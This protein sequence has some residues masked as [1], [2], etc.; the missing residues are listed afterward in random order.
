MSPSLLV[1]LVLT[2]NLNVGAI[3]VKLVPKTGTPPSP[4]ELPGFT[5][6]SSSRKLFIYGGRLGNMY[7]D[8]WEFDLDTQRWT[9]IHPGVVLTPGPRSD[10]FMRV[11]QNQREILLFGGDTSTGP[12]SDVWLYDIE[13][14]SVIY[15]QW[16]LVDDKGKSPPRAFYRSVCKYLH[17]GK[18]Y[19]AVYG[20]QG[21]TGLVHN[22]YMYYL[23]RLEIETFTWTEYQSSES[24]PETCG[25]KMGYY[26]GSLYLWEGSCIYKFDLQS[27]EW[28]KIVPSSKNLNA[29]TDNGM[30]IY[31]DSLYS[32]HGWDKVNSRAM[33]YIYK[34]NLIGE[35]YEV[36]QTVIEKEGV[37]DWLF[38]FEC[39]DNM[40]YIFSGGAESGNYNSLVM[41]DLDNL[42]TPL[43]Q[44]SQNIETPTARRGHAMEVYNDKLYIFG[45]IDNNGQK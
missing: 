36:E 20:G 18:E 38:G 35:I 26:N 2:L 9:E 23:Y 1:M 6:D 29:V 39:K 43:T 8:L 41:L 30:C 16:K 12:I 14:E 15:I 34:V 21:K 27:E 3:D 32:V 44:L 10:A 28:N 42:S 19:I 33:K 31:N 5:V 22:L 37:A 4:R 25:Q 45:G 40:M 24:W 7:D 13:N 11:L 17:Q